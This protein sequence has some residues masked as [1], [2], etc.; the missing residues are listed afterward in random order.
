[1]KTTVYKY[2]DYFS[3]IN[4]GYIFRENCRLIHPYFLEYLRENYFTYYTVTVGV[5][6]TDVFEHFRH[7][8]FHYFI[9]YKKT[10]SNFP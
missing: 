3:L 7:Q 9:N 2:N 5:F 4:D 10:P 8:D 1:M 6:C